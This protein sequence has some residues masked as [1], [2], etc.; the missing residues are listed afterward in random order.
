MG[1][2]LIQAFESIGICL[3]TYKG[4]RSLDDLHIYILTRIGIFGPV[5]LGVAARD[6]VVCMSSRLP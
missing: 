6:D 3:L 4:R 1:V 2:V 5:R